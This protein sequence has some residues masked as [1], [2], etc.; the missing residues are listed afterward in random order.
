MIYNY[1]EVVALILLASTPV[2]AADAFNFG[3]QSKGCYPKSAIEGL[4]L[5]NTYI[6]QSSGYCEQQCLGNHVIALTEGNAC[7]C[8]SNLDVTSAVDSSFG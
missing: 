4:S 8:G 1:L 5:K 6:Y 3:Y 7:Y 2:Q